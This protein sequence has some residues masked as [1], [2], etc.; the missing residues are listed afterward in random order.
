MIHAEVSLYPLKTNQASDV[1]NNSIDALG[2]Q[3]VQYSVGSM[4]THLH[5]NEEQV[6]QG[7]QQMFQNAKKSGE[8]SMVITI[9]N[10]AD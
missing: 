8:V 9:T 10:A 2:S 5:G 4:S 1:I 6:W 7:L 3:G